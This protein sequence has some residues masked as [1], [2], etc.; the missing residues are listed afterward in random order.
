VKRIAANTLKALLICALLLY[1]GDWAVF[2]IRSA[3]GNAFSSV[4]VDEFLATPLKGHKEE[5]DYT[6]TDMIS[7]VRAIFPH[8]DAPACWW[9]RRHSQHW[10]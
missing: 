5:Y 8:S 10:E 2:R 9:V 3:R 7:C 4:Q 1:A 6:G